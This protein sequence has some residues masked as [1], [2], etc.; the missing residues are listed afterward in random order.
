MHESST[1]HWHNGA[2]HQGSPNRN[3]ASLALRYGAGFFE[4]VLWNGQT[5]WLL[6]AHVARLHTS[7]AAFGFS[8]S[9]CD[10]SAAI[11]TLVSALHMQGTPARINIYAHIEDEN[12]PVSP[13][14]T[15]APWQLPAPDRTW[16]LSTEAFAEPAH[17]AHHFTPLAA[18]KTTNY[19]YHWLLRRQSMAH[20]YD[21]ALL[22]HPHG[23]VLE[24]TAAAIVCSDGTRFCTP[25]SRPRLP[26]VTLAAA[27]KVLTIHDEHIP[28][29]ELAR[30][31]HV[32]VLNALNGM[33]PVTAI[34][35]S[36]ITAD[37]E[38][39]H[40]LRHVLI[41]VGAAQAGPLRG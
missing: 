40:G 6:D 37:Y 30:F 14:I 26:S 32:Y 13:C 33:L 35:D 39:C 28:L 22:L 31:R 18:H 10:Y 17:P 7:L 20:G 11:H 36:P 23:Y 21:D 24:S 4:T 3:P 12:A 38:T 2:L 16:R 1:L 8:V 27:R 19:M 29:P 9:A 5:P 41:G 25:K 15:A 34:D